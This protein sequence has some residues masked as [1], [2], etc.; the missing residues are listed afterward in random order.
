MPSIYKNLLKSEPVAIFLFSR[1][2]LFALAFF[3][4]GWMPSAVGVGVLGPAHPFPGALF[5][6]AFCRWDVQWYA[7]VADLGY[8]NQGLTTATQQNTAFF[9]LMPMVLHI[10]SFITGNT[11][12]SGIIIS[13]LT[14]LASLVVLYHWVTERFGKAV[15]RRACALLCFFPFSFFFATGYPE[16]I[17]LLLSLLAFRSAEKKKWVHASLWASLAAIARPTGMFV[18]LGLIVQA[19]QT[20]P[21]NSRNIKK[22]FAPIFFIG[23]LCLLLFFGYFH[24]RFGEPFLY[25]VSRGM[26]SVW[27]GGGLGFEFFDI[28]REWTQPEFFSRALAGQFEAPRSLHLLF[29]IAALA[30]AF[31]AN[32]SWN[33]GERI[34][35][36]LTLITAFFNSLGG[37]GRYVSSLYPLFLSLAL[38][39]KTES[40]SFSGVLGVFAVMQGALFLLFSHWFWVG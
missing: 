32:R 27:G 30:I 10:V 13:N 24:V 28:L 20:S 35:V 3:G 34:W 5:L 2:V 19:L 16:S 36:T 4:M 15:S 40:M 7:S 33:T 31:K 12:L 39:F 8:L 1:L 18:L 26:D 14:F 11:F 17:L 9:P 37:M 29:G 38:L 23:P 21:L 6:D 22:V 25:F